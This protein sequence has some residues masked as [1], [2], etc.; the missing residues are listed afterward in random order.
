MPLRNQVG[1]SFHVEGIIFPLLLF[2]LRLNHTI[3]R[4]LLKTASD[5][6]FK[7]DP[8]HFEIFFRILNFGVFYGFRIDAFNKKECHN[9]V[10]DSFNSHVLLF[11]YVTSQVKIRFFQYFT[12]G[13]LNSRLPLVYLPFGEI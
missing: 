8:L 5:V 13:A 10:F 1:K 3:H 12:Q 11:V 9:S 4:V 2:F 6:L 7:C